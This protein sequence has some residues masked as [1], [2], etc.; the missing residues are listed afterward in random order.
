MPDSS[1]NLYELTVT[2]RLQPFDSLGTE[3]RSFRKR[4]SRRKPECVALCPFWGISP[5][6]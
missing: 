6:D 4:S 1:M 3:W 5:L 2:G